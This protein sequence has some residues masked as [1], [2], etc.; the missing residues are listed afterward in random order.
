MI[1]T[2]IFFPT[3]LVIKDM[4]RNFLYGL[5]EMYVSSST[6]KYINSW[7]NNHNDKN[8]PELPPMV[9]TLFNIVCGIKFRL[10]MVHVQVK[11]L[12]LSNKVNFNKKYT[13]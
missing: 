12:Q 6:I 2:I 9:N 4:V 7:T 5:Y 1:F 11:L 13:I 3:G 8:T 10:N